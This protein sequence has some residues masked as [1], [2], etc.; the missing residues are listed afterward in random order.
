MKVCFIIPY[1][2]HLPNY[3]SLFLK[4]CA[5]NKNFDWLLITDDP[6]PYNYPNN[7]RV[8]YMSF[9][10]N[11][12][13][14]QSKFDFQV[15]LERAYKLCDYK[16]AY[17]YIYSEF[18]KGYSHW[19]HCDTDMLMGDLD[20]F[21][22]N[23]LLDEY[24]KLF[25]LGHMT[26]YRNTEDNNKIFMNDLEGIPIYKNVYSSNASYCFDEVWKDDFNVNT[27][28]KRAGKSIFTI[29]YSLNIDF[30]STKFVRV[31]YVGK[32][33]PNNGHGYVYETY[34][35]SVYLWE[36]GHIV[37][38]F[39][40]NNELKRE[41]YMYLHLQK[42]KMKNFVDNQVSII[43]IVPNS[44]LPLEF[45]KVTVDNFVKIKKKDI[46]SHFL[47]IKIFPR[48]KQLRKKLGI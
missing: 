16:P 31:V 48:L 35:P 36:N 10:E 38:Y 32:D 11:Y 29:D 34:K 37:R 26:I 23:Q 44:F 28:F 8:I 6:T 5:Y 3:F 14:I 39:K 13:L 41:E 12:S 40:N 42:R 43:K 1:F 9:E 33:E 22:T 21:L 47:R 18:L 30:G 46:N 45:D 19:G 15:A 2:G 17:G 25:C 4:T 27:L 24:D 7:F 20:S